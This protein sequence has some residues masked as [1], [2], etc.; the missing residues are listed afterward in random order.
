M[1]IYQTTIISS[2]NLGDDVILNDI[3]DIHDEIVI[4]N[5]ECTA[6]KIHNE[7]VEKYSDEDIY[8]V[9]SV[10]NKFTRNLNTDNIK[11]STEIKWETEFGETVIMIDTIAKE[12]I[13]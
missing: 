7:L 10:N 12:V 6:T 13:Y 9:K 2:H 5:N 4:S 11:I 3:I 8:Y 1:T